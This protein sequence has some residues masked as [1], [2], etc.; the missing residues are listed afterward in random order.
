[1]G[2]KHKKLGH[3]DEEGMACAETRGQEGNLWTGGSHEKLGCSPSIRTGGDNLGTLRE[4]CSNATY[5]IN[6][7]KYIFHRSKQLIQI[8]K[9]SLHNNGLV[10]TDLW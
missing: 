10:I 9:F 5:S 6:H 4:R 8:F 1:M 7:L 3:F 2:N